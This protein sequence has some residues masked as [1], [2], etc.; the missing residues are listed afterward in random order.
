MSDTTV[1]EVSGLSFSYENEPA[2]SE[3]EFTVERGTTVGILGPNG[4][5]KTTLLRLLL[6][7]LRPQRGAIKISGRP[8]Y[9]PQTES[10]RLD[11]PVTAFEVVLMG[12]YAQIPWYRRLGHS[13]RQRAAAALERVG[14]PELAREQFGT[15]SG[16]QRQRVLIARA[17]VQSATVILLDEPFTGVDEP[18]ARRIMELLDQLRDEGRTI[19]ISTHDI[20][21]ARHWDRVLCLNRRQIAFGAPAETL[22]ESV[23]EQTYGAE[24]VLLDGGRQAIT[25]QHHHH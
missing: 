14:L 20:D 2:V 24:I 1:I 19:L 11:F 9:V 25:V 12:T 7:D 5:G 15:L 21:Q 13:E 6:S 3:L 18:S 10:S 4:S 22:T 8:A 23:L 17:L 16:G